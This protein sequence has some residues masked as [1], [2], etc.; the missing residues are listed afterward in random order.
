MNGWHHQAPGIF[1]R[2]ARVENEPHRSKYEQVRWFTRP[3]NDKGGTRVQMGDGHL[4]ALKAGELRDL[5]FTKGGGWF[6]LTW[7]TPEQ[8]WD[9]ATVRG[10]FTTPELAAKGGAS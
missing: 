8:T 4:L 1:D 7:T 6:Y 2:S 5:V 9:Q 3:R 10:P